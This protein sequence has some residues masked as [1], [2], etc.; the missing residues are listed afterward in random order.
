MN[1]GLRIA[2]C[3]LNCYGSPSLRHSVT[4]SLAI[5]LAVGLL[6]T[7]ASAQS[8]DVTASLSLTDGAARAEA[9][10]PVRIKIT[11]NLSY[12][13]HHFIITSGGPVVVSVPWLDVR[14]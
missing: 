6:S 12:N 14:R 3:G 5:L 11:N 1:C 2:D 4:P 13:I 10:V 7:T 9:Y 8:I